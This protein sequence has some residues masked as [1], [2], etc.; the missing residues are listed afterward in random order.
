MQRSVLLLLGL[1]AF[2]LGCRPDRNEPAAQAESIA[3]F[4]K[5]LQGLN[6]TPLADILDRPAE[7]SQKTVAVAGPVARACTRKGCWMEIATGTDAGARACRV[8]F[9]D[10]A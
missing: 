7:F 6:R 2:S 5:P 10:Y 4:G 9:E 8:T 1:S 3:R